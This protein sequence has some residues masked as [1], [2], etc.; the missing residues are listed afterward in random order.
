MSVRPT[1]RIYRLTSGKYK[2]PEELKYIQLKG[3]R[4]VCYSCTEERSDHI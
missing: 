4:D 1:L 2:Y 3:L